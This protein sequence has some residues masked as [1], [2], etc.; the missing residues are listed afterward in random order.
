[1][2][3]HRQR[4]TAQFRPVL[5]KARWAIHWICPNESVF[6]LWVFFLSIFFLERPPWNLDNRLFF[7][8][9]FL[10]QPLGVS[11]PVQEFHDFLRHLVFLLVIFYGL[12]FTRNGTYRKPHESS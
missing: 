10:R 12:I 2:G 5:G 6:C 9:E 7:D 3:E 4:E 8:K 11:N 1:M